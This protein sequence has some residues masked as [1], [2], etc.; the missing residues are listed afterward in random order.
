MSPQII[1]SV[2]GCEGE[3]E[4]TGDQH[5]IDSI[6]FTPIH[7]AVLNIS[8]GFLGAGVDAGAW[9]DVAGVDFFVGD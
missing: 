1:A 7:F 5:D 4:K 2:L 8:Y 6:V 3:Y 9:F